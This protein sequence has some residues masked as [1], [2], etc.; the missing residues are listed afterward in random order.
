MLADRPDPMEDQLGLLRSIGFADVDCA[1]K[2]ARFAV[3]VC[4]RVNL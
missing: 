4:R 2:G 3:L 1:A